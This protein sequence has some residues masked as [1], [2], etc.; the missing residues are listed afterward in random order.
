M[1]WMENPAASNDE[2]KEEDETCKDGSAQREPP[3]YRWEENP[4]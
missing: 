1:I 4:A 2:L 3:E